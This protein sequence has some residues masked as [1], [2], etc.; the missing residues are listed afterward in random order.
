MSSMDA[1]PV[2]KA[3]YTALNSQQGS[4]QDITYSSSLPTNSQD[5]PLQW[6]VEKRMSGGQKTIIIAVLCIIVPMLGL[7][8]LLIGLVL[9]YRVDRRQGGLDG[10]LTFTQRSDSDDDAYYV[11]FNATTLATI[12]SWSSTVAP[13]LAVAALALYSYPIS[14]RLKEHSQTHGRDLPTPFQF[15]LLLEALSGSITAFFSLGAY[16][17]WKSHQKMVSMLRSSFIVLLVA[18]IIGLAIHG[19]SKVLFS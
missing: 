17:S 14:K 16:L 6:Q 19:P 15:G 3:R 5:Q 2:P 9:G 13:L 10:P 18:T 11:N 8:G 1:L 4:Q 12:A 7:A